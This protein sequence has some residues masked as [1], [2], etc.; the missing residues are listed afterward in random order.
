MFHHTMYGSGPH[1]IPFGQ[2]GFSG[3][4]GIAMRVLKPLFFHY[5]VDAVFSGHDELMERSEETG[6][7]QLADGRD[8]PQTIHFYDSGIGGDGLRGASTGFDNPFRKFLAHDDS[9]EVWNGEQ[10]VSGGKHYGH[11][12]VNV[13]PDS[14][15][16]WQVEVTPVH[17][18]PLNDATG[19][20]TGWERRTYDDTVKFTQPK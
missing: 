7:E 20:V 1:S 16:V 9:A 14:H 12:E 3:Q 11:L 18:F 19:N 10:L 8:R 2:K 13:A 5:G 17:V 15:G 4:S 6:V